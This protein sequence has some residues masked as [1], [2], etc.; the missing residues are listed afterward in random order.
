MEDKSWNLDVK[1]EVKQAMPPMPRSNLK[2]DGGFSVQVSAS[3]FLFPDTLIFVIW[4]FLSFQQTLVFR[5]MRKRPLNPP[6]A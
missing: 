6:R 4:N 5:R 3:M 2:T 1:W